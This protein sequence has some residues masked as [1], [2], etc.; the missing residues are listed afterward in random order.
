MNTWVIGRLSEIGSTLAY[1]VTN[2]HFPGF[3]ESQSQWLYHVGNSWKSPSDPSD[4][5]VACMNGKYLPNS[6]WKMDGK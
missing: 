6:Q 5:T 1:I 2:N 3:T 4:I